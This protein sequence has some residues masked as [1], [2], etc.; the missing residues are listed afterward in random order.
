MTK[1]KFLTALFLTLLFVSQASFAWKP[2]RTF[3]RKSKV[4][5]IDDKDYPIKPKR[6]PLSE[7][8]GRNE[9]TLTTEFFWAWG[10]TDFWQL[11]FTQ[12]AQDIYQ[13]YFGGRIGAE[14]ITKNGYSIRGFLGHQNNFYSSIGQSEIQKG[15]FHMGAMVSKYIFKEFSKFWDPYVTA[16]FQ[17]INGYTTQ[18]RGY[19][20]V[21]AGTRIR[22]KDQEFWSVRI[23]PT[24]VT[25]IDDANWIQMNMGVNI[26]F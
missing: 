11:Y 22:F 13:S 14:F 24:Y 1:F 17:Y 7:R 18:E 26:H 19:L 10:R 6:K 25:S 23:E 16:G 21:G 2:A 5:T 20:V 12:P 8:K 9:I 3:D 15:Y 4:T